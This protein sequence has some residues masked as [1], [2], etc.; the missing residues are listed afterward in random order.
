LK[1]PEKQRW[2]EELLIYEEIALGKIPSKMPLNR[3]IYVHSHTRLNVNGKTRQRK[4]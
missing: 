1:F 4:N 3:E 2:R